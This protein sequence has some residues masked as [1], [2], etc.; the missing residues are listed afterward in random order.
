[1]SPGLQTRIWQ[2]VLRF[3]V[4]KSRIFPT[5]TELAIARLSSAVHTYSS[6]CCIWI[7]EPRYWWPYRT[8]WCRTLHKVQIS[9]LYI[10]Q[11]WDRKIGLRR[12]WYVEQRVYN[13]GAINLVFLYSALGGCS[14]EFS[15]L[16]SVPT[17]ARQGM[18]WEG[19]GCF[20]MWVATTV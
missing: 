7:L 6:K 18:M 11:F 16:F 8:S 20:L 1:M 2:A 12:S 19:Y 4:M 9:F 15:P 14:G 10:L 5:A 17:A 3:F 13:A